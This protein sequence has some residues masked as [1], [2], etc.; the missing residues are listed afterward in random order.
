MKTPRSF[1]PLGITT[2]FI[3]FIAGTA[4]M[5][6]LACRSNTDLV[7]RDY[8]EQEIRYQSRIDALKRTQDLSPEAGIAYEATSDSIRITLPAE[9]ARPDIQGRIELYRPSAAGMDQQLPLQLD[10]TGAQTLNA[11]PLQSGLWRVK[12]FWAFGGQDYSAD[13]Q[14]VVRPKRT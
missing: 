12:I 7:A 14:I 3:L 5:I 9:Q 4:T 6:A 8:Y 2:A 11:A 13:Q 1:W 10:T